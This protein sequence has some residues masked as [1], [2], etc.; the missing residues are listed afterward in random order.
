MPLVPL[1]SSLSD[2]TAIIMIITSA[3]SATEAVQLSFYVVKKLTAIHNS[4]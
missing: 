2:F 3:Q 4:A 1:Q